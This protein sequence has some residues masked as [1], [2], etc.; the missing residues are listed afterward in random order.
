MVVDD[1]RKGLFCTFCRHTNQ[2]DELNTDSR[3]GR[4]MFFCCCFIVYCVCIMSKMYSIFLRYARHNIMWL[5]WNDWCY[6]FSR[7]APDIIS[8][9]G[10][11]PAVF[12]KSGSGRIWP[13]DLRPDLSNFEDSNITTFRFIFLRLHRCTLH[14][15][16]PTCHLKDCIMWLR[17][18]DWCYVLFSL[19]WF[20]LWHV[21]ILNENT[22]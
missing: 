15:L 11:N 3:T 18:N 10:R 7:V 1:S 21:M 22:K 9:P 19:P 5:R 2:L 20:K 17:W 6:V 16:P 14:L 8:G 4:P 12:F 13:P